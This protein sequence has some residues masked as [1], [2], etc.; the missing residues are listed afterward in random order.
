MSQTTTFAAP[1]E[2]SEGYRLSTSF[3]YIVRRVGLRIGEL[4]DRAVAPYGVDVSMYRVVAALAEG[5][6]Q[7]LGKLSEITSIELSTLSRLVGAMA[8]KGFLTRRRPRGNGRIVEISLSLKGRRLAADL[9]PVAVRFEAAAVKGLGEA[10]VVRLK[11]QL[12][13]AYRNLD[14]LE[15]ELA[16]I[17]VDTKPARRKRRSARTEAAD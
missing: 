13:V 2:G 17:S 14:S 1:L 6:R 4:F 8:A 15:Q 11:A 5:D 3:P 16:A 9:M 10:D 7:Q 12:E